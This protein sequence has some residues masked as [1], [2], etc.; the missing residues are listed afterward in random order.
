[1]R[2]VAVWAPPLTLGEQCSLRPDPIAGE[3]GLA[4]PLREPH[5]RSRCFGLRSGPPYFVMR[6]TPTTE[7]LTYTL[8]YL[9]I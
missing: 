1:M 3:E 6:S 5:P 7:C 9:L 2:L 4:A 8:T